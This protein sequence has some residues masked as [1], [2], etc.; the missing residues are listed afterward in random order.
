MSTWPGLGD[1]LRRLRGVTSGESE[2]EREQPKVGLTGAGRAG[3][4][5]A[6][7]R[8]TNMSDAI[9]DAWEEQR[10]LH[11]GERVIPARELFGRR[12]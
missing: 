6:R 9:R 10:G 3:V 7:K 12:R 4:T 2:R 1:E 5:P 8:P 11:G